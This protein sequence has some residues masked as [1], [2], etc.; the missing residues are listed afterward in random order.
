MTRLLLVL[1]LAGVLAGSAA[2]AA[3]TWATRADAVCRT[4]VARARAE[5]GTTAP[6]TLAQ[7]HTFTVKA[8][9]LEAENLAAL[10][11]LPGRTPAGTRA[12]AV[13]RNDIVE[14]KAALA[15]WNA[16]NTELFRRRF[17]AWA[18]DHRPK[19]AFAAAGAHACG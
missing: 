11:K 9:T 12:L 7:A 16:G 6:K 13:L 2:A 4:F 19:R 3:D 5:L 15:A 1:A 17:I 14:A 18:N 10:R 8:T